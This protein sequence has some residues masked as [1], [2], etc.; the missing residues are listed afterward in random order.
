M[1]QIPAMDPDEEAEASLNASEAKPQ[2]N[3]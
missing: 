3:A 1:G 2:P